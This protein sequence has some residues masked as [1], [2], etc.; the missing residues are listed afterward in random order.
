Y[1]GT[2]D[3]RER[4]TTPGFEQ[5][6]VA[7]E[8]GRPPRL[9]RRYVQV[10]GH[11]LSLSDVRFRLRHH[12]PRTLDARPAPPVPL[13]PYVRGTANCPSGW[14]TGFMATPRTFGRRPFQRLRPALPTLAS[15]CVAFP[16]CPT[17]AR[18]CRFTR[19]ISPD[20]MR[21]LA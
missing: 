14:S 20:G 10:L 17:V 21:R 2:L 19:R 12:A 1:A 3:R 4:Q 8:V 6:L 5:R 18:H 7:D 15:S 13:R 16:T 11:G 9:L